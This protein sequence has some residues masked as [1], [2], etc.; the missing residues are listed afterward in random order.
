M[1]LCPLGGRRKERYGVWLSPVCQDPLVLIA[2]KPSFIRGFQII[3]FSFI[4]SIIIYQ[5]KCL[6]R[7]NVASL[8][9][10]SMQV[11]FDLKREDKHQIFSL[12][13]P[14][15][16]KKGFPS[17]FQRWQRGVEFCFSAS[18][19]TR[20]F[21]Y[22]WCIWTPCSYRCWGLNF[23]VF[24]QWKPLGCDLNLVQVHT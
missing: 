6:I 22:V 12:Y 17:I 16:R 8:S 15:F 20:G 13:S 11:W 24:G 18:L 21:N 23:S 10:W 9:I 7:I 1:V 2:W 19:L 14:V 5:L 4:C 3:M